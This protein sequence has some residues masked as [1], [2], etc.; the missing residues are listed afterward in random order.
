MSAIIAQTILT[1]AAKLANKP[2]MCGRLYRRVRQNRRKLMWSYST[3][4]ADILTNRSNRANFL[5]TV[6]D[7]VTACDADGLEFDY[8][9]GGGTA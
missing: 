6:A 3:P 2:G 7:A 4:P 8:E 5:A 9:G 1:A